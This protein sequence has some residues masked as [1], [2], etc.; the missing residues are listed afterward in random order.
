M[1][2]LL[3]DLGAS[4]NAQGSHYGNALQVAAC[5]VAKL[6]SVEGTISMPRVATTAT[7]SSCAQE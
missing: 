2:R 4:I 5:W 6:L 1:A 3:L 7:P